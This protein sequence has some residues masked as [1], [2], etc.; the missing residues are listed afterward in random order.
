MTIPFDPQ[1]LAERVQH[2]SERERRVIAHLI[3]HKTV[4]RDSNAVFDSGMTFGQRVADRVA[5]VVGGWPFIITQSILLVLWIASNIYLVTH[6]R[7][8]AFDPYPFILLNLALSFQAAYTGPIVMMSQNRQNEK[9]RHAAQS[10]FECNLKAEA[11]IRVIMEHLVHQDTMLTDLR[12]QLDKMQAV[13][14][15]Q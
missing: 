14:S 13:G 3:H 7:D 6:Y 10:D 8:K 4:S 11:E 1:T 5:N 12:A 9:D 15:R 2:L